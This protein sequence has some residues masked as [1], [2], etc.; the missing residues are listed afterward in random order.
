MWLACLLVCRGCGSHGRG[1]MMGSGYL[2]SL[3][4]PIRYLQPPIRR[5]QPP[6]RRLHASSGLSGRGWGALKYLT[7]PGG[8]AAYRLLNPPAYLAHCRTRGRVS[9]QPLPPCPSP[10]L[11]RRNAFNWTLFIKFL[12]PEALLLLVAVGVS[13]SVARCHGPISDLVV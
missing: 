2:H 12:F 3:R 6:I 10:S 5:L 11:S 9:I 1:W 13:Y 7:I 4:P 8:L